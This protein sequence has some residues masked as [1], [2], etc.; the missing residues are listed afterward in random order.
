M[1]DEAKDKL[2]LISPYLEL[3]N[4]LKLALEDR[5][6]FRIDTVR[7]YGRVA[8]LNPDDSKWLQEMP[9]IKLLFHKDLHAKCY[10]N[11]KEAIVTSM[12]LYMYS[13][14]NNVEMGIYISKEE[15][16]EL[17]KKLHSE[18]EKIK[19]GSKHRTI[20][21]QKV[22]EK[23]PEK[24]EEKSTPKKVAKKDINKQT[25]YCIRTGVEIPF[26][27]EKPMSLQCI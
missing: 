17:Y 21:V 22:E 16:P 2:Y 6:E 23:K 13:R 19:R 20:S 18:V 8:D 5:A 27:V 7:V 12:N 10:L 3:N 4:Q 26:D 11:K 24:T 25:G 14:Q 15:D 9:D 1:I